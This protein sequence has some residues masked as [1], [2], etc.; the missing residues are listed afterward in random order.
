[1]VNRKC[2][3]GMAKRIEANETDNIL[4]TFHEHITGQTQL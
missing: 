4:N 2:P 3:N 1:M